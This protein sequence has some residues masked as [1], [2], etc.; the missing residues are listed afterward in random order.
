MAEQVD[1]L[2]HG[3]HVVTMNPRREV[4][5]GGAVAVRGSAIVDIGKY[6]ELNRRYEPRRRVGGPRFVVTPGMVNTHL[7]ITGEPLT[8][9]YV[10]DDT[11]FEENVFQ[12]L[13][14]LYSVYT[15]DDERLSAQLAAAEL[16]KS[17]C[18]SFLEAGT[19]RFVDAVVD[20]L[21]EVGIRARIGKWVWDLPP[22]PEVY[23]QTTDEAI[24]NLDET[25]RTHRSVD[26]GRIQ[27]WSM[28]VGHTTC[29]DALWRA[30]K[31]AA[32]EY[33]T[34]LN[35]HMSPAAMDPEG[36]L[37]QFGKRPIEHLADL[38]ILGPNVVIVHCVHVDDN[39]VKLLAHHRCNVAHCPTTALKVSYGV[40]QIGKMPEMYAAGVNVTIGTDGNNAAN[41]ADM[42]RATY[43]VA[44][45][46]KDARRDPTMFPAEVAYEMATLG[47]AKALLSDDEIGSLETGKKADL[48]LHDRDRPEWTPLLNVANQLV[49]SADGRSVHTVLVDGRVVVDNYRLTTLDEHDLYARAQ[50]AGEAIVERTGLP[51]RAKWPVR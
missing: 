10:P 7:H 25:L 20:G 49:W 46:F 48:V 43:L 41:Y 15:E 13:V 21:V 17:G 51:D 44:G 29:S 16:L 1:L 36:F 37:A 30:A 39:E 11:P 24:A 31:D 2:V 28:I 23:R 26:G 34:G 35:F 50:R 6:D 8:R 38:G 5:L 19:V 47:G 40:T 42:M 22:E 27:A 14:P 45:L 32:D 9:G 18:T 4:V 3:S 33:D 12:W